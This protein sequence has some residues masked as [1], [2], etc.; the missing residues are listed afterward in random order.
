MQL[1]TRSKKPSARW[2]G[3]LLLGCTFSLLGAGTNAAQA[4]DWAFRR[5]YFTHELPPGELFAGAPMPISRSAYR[6]PYV[7][8]YPGVTVQSTWRLN[9]VQLR[10][11]ASTDT[12]FL[13]QGTTEFRP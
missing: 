11:G 1:F 2:F 10:S 3:L 8:H 7:P 9:R 4:E 6:I 5:S 13:W 12:Q